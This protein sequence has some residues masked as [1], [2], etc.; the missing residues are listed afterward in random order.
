MRS[1][2]I[3][4]ELVLQQQYRSPEFGLDLPVGQQGFQLG[5]VHQQRWPMSVHQLRGAV[6]RPHIWAQLKGG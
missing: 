3:H 4:L 2:K 6:I 1:S 5:G